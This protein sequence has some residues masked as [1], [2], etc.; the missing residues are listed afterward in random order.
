MYFYSAHFSMNS[1][2]SFA[3]VDMHV[4]IP[5]WDVM[6]FLHLANGMWLLMLSYC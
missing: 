3:T 5:F 4:C 1:A 6:A 2:I